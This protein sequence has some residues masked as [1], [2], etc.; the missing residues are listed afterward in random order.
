MGLP[1][2]RKI[3]IDVAYGTGGFGYWKP[4][5]D[6]VI[7]SK[8]KTVEA[9]S[10]PR[11]GIQMSKFK[12]SALQMKGYQTTFANLKTLDLTLAVQCERADLAEQFWSFIEKIGNNVEDL[13]VRTTRTSRNTPTPNAHGGYLPKEFNL[14]K[15][16]ALKLV[17]VAV[18]PMDLKKLLK[19]V[20]TEAIVISQCWMR[21]PKEDWF[22]VVKHLRYGNFDKIKELRLALSG[23][24]GSDNY[25]LPNLVIES[26]GDWR[27]E[28]NN[29]K[30]TL[31]SGL[32]KQYVTHK[33]LWHEIGATFETD[34]FWDSL[35]NSKWTSL[36][37]TRWK[38]LQTAYETHRS[39]M[40]KLGYGYAS[41]IDTYKAAIVQEQYD[42]TVREIKAEVDSDCEE[43]E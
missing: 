26:K 7:R 37:T 4:V 42:R 25:D 29:C 31:R 39:A 34:W 9:V 36:R 12:F 35:T 5:I 13:T 19:N 32:S 40:A 43:V 17:D 27:N 33:N 28:G 15:L 6:A 22:E 30:V 8:S 21:N 1:D 16:K 23:H 11:C 18:T 10:G 20:A 2:I 41:D 14:P 3:E 38:R 24:Y